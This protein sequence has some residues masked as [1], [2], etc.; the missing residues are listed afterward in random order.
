MSWCEILVAAFL[1]VY[2]QHAA[3]SFK[4]EGGE[5]TPETCQCLFEF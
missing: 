3:A 1:D 4:S 2:F 5:W